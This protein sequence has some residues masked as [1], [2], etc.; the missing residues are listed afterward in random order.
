[1]ELSATT[2]QVKSVIEHITDSSSEMRKIITDSSIRSFIQTVKLDHVI[3]KADVCAILWE[4]SDKEINDLAGN[5]CCRL[6]KWYYEGDGH[7]LYVH[8]PSFKALETPHQAV[9]CNGLQALQHHQEKNI[10]LK[11]DRLKK[12]EAASITVLEMLGELEEEII[13]DTKSLPDSSKNIES[14]DSVLF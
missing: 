12:M 10:S 3:W 14:S 11:I 6:G 1:M 7:Q 2:S 9:H 8:L 5:T 13:R 4:L